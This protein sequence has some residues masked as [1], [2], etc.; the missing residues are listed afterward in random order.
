MVHREEVDLRNPSINDNC[1]FFWYLF[2]VFNRCPSTIEGYRIGI[3]DTL[4]NSRLNIS[5]NM[6]IAKLIASFTGTNPRTPGPT[7]NGIDLSFY[8]LTQH[9]YEP[10]NLSD[11]GPPLMRPLGLLIERY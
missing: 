2:N 3:V 8:R 11:E 4:G 10:Q 6:D 9:P 5:A 1:N 7:L